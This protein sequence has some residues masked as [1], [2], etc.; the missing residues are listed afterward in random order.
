MRLLKVRCGVL[1]HR[2]RHRGRRRWFGVHDVPGLRPIVEASDRLWCVIVG[3]RSG[4][5]GQGA[6]SCWVGGMAGDARES[7][8]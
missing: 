3:G 4:Y 8:W 7:A 1:E 2:E 5:C 6:D